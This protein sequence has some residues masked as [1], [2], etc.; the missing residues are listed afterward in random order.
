MYLGPDGSHLREDL[1][2]VCSKWDSKSCNHSFLLWAICCCNVLIAI[3][4]LTACFQNLAKFGSFFFE[5]SKN[6]SRRSKSDFSGLKFTK[7][8]GEESPILPPIMWACL[9][10]GLRSHASSCGA[11]RA[12]HILGDSQTW[13][14]S[15][16]R[17]KANPV[18]C[19]QSSYMWIRKYLT[20]TRCPIRAHLSQVKFLHVI[21]C[22]PPT[23]TKHVRAFAIRKGCAFSVYLTLSSKCSLFVASLEV[24]SRDSQLPCI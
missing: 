1:A 15:G 13:A 21:S 20:C 4:L 17:K 2:E 9:R 22:C 8:M 3:W 18:T 12:P 19:I 5:N 6:T 10:W 11:N 14:L 23:V 16:A 7:I 24:Q